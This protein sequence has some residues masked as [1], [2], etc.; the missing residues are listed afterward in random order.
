V[1]TKTKKPALTI[2]VN[3]DALTVTDLE[4]IDK[5]TRG[6]A[7]LSDEI[8]IFERVVVGG[9]RHLRASDIR[10]IRDTVLD[11]LVRDANDPN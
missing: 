7:T 5:A 1:T 6:E 10:K 8:A 2:D 4:V 9:V 3:I 11:A